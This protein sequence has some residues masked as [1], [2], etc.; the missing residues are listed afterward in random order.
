MQTQRHKSHEITAEKCSKVPKHSIWSNMAMK[1][2]PSSAMMVKQYG[3]K[4]QCFTFI[5]IVQCFA[6]CFKYG[7]YN[8]VKLHLV[9]G[10]LVTFDYRKGKQMKVNSP[11]FH[12]K[13]SI[14]LYSM[15]PPPVMFVDL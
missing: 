13:I 1:H 12:R 6:G 2:T 10:Q 4:W 3:K 5:A 14:V 15:V 7:N 9:R 11:F 8:M